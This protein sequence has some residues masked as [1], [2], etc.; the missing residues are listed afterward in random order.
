[1]DCPGPHSGWR[2]NLKWTVLNEVNFQKGRPLSDF[3]RFIFVPFISGRFLQLTLKCH[4]EI[5]S[6]MVKSVQELLTKIGPEIITE[7]DSNDQCR[8][9]I[10]RRNHHQKKLHKRNHS[11]KSDSKRITARQVRPF[12]FFKFSTILA[13]G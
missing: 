3:E 11:K 13:S 1:M 6:G 5:P 2:W 7:I 10:A 4:L 8:I 9:Q 12:Q